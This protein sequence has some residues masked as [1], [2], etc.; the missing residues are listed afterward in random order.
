MNFNHFWNTCLICIIKNITLIG[1]TIKLKQ[2]SLIKPEFSKIISKTH[3]LDHKLYL[4]KNSLFLFSLVKSISLLFFLK[5][6]SHFLELKFHL[7]IIFL[8][9]KS[10]VFTGLFL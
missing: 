2:I 3:K 5:I 6:F 1:W 4:I 9:Q 7:W 8:K 10:S